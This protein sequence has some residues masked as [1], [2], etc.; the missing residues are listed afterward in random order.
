MKKINKLKTQI[1]ISEL[2][3]QSLRS[4]INKIKKI[5][6]DKDCSFCKSIQ[7]IMEEK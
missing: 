5:G 3:I 6:Y 7:K 1:L 2:L 4:K